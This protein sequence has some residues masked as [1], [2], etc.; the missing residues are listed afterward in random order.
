MNPVKRIP[1]ERFEDAR[2]L[3]ASLNTFR[4]KDVKRMYV[5][6]HNDTQTL[7]GWNGHRFEKKWFFCT[8]GRFH[9]RLVAVDNW[10]TPAPDLPV[11][12]VHLSDTRS[13]LLC[14]PGGYASLI[15]AEIPG[16]ILTVF[17][18]NTVEESLADSY[19]FAASL[20]NNQKEAQ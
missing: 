14:V 7:R 4:F 11:E 19:R 3:I 16:S 5:L 12:H 13:E 2:G 18:N 10:E 9:I 6:H 20:W 1:G 15:Q 17:S 8:K